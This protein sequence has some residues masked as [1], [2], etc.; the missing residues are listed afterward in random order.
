MFTPPLPETTDV[1]G[2]LQETLDGGGYFGERE[3]GSGP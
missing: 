1:T 2:N 3:I